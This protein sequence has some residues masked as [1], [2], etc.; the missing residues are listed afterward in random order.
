M[1]LLSL[2]CFVGK[3]QVWHEDVMAPTKTEQKEVTFYWCQLSPLLAAELF[4]RSFFISVNVWPDYFCCFCFVNLN[5]AF[6]KPTI[7]CISLYTKHLC[8]WSSSHLSIS[9]GRIFEPGS[10]TFHLSSQFRQL[11]VLKGG[12]PPGWIKGEV[13]SSSQ[14]K[15]SPACYLLI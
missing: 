15:T 3:P 1:I 7:C 4:W 2:E 6:V 10:V 13:Y 14:F 5:Y 8:Y 12:P 11:A 9:I